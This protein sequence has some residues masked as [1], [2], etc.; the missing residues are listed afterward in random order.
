MLCLCATG[1]FSL[2]SAISTRANG[3]VFEFT[4]EETSAGEF[5][6]TDL[7]YIPT[8]L[9]LTRP[10][11]AMGTSTACWPWANGWRIALRA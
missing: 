10:R 11:T 9:A 1:N 8:W 2:T 4:I 7:T 6:I 5:E 3:I